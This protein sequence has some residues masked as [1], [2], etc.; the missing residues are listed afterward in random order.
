MKSNLKTVSAARMAELG[1]R[2]GIASVALGVLVL[3]MGWVLNLQPVQTVWPGRPRL[4][5]NEA[6]LFV[7]LGGALLSMVRRPT[8]AGGRSRIWIGRGLAALAVLLGAA[9]LGEYLLGWNARVD[10]LLFDDPLATAIGAFPGRPSFPSALG[11]VALG[12]GLVLLDVQIRGVWPAE[13]LAVITMQIALLGLIGHVFGVQ[14]LYGSLAFK[15]GNGMAMHT[16]AG[17]L[18]LGAGILCARADHGLMAVL[19]SD[20]PGGTLARRWMFMPVLVLL[21]MGL[22]YLALNRVLGVD[23]SV[24]SWALFMTCLTVLTAAVW[25][26]AEVLHQAGLER[27]AAQRTLEQRVSERTAELN[28]ANVALSAAKDELARANQELEAVVHERTAHLKETIRALETVC[29]NIAHDL[30]APNRAM[31]GFAQVV[32]NKHGASL[33]ALG[34]D[35]LSRIVKAAC[36]SDALTLDL[37]AYGRLGHAELPCKVQSLQ[38]HVTDALSTLAGEISATGAQVEVRAPLPDV[39]ANPTTLHQ[40]LMN[41]LTNALKFVADGVA[42]QVRI[43]TEDAGVCWRVLVEDNGIGVPVEQRENIFGVFQRLDASGKYP[44]SGIGLAIVRKGVERMGGKVGVRS[45]EQG[46]C[47]W[48]ELPKAPSL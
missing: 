44:G 20:T 34:R 25:G 5:P 36:R 41:L 3:V 6:L 33:D 14:E 26:T 28:S 16:A 24:G 40:V 35:C 43:S 7:G 47:F 23:Q 45:L 19:R 11:V 30:R 48:F 18:V 29:Y 13:V 4:M 17:L 8:P 46:S 21:M 42:P 10:L 37:L 12:A 27:D 1:H 15:T 39:F 31:A 9:T 32:L 2:A 22:V 38:T